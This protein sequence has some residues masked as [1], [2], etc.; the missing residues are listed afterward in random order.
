MDTNCGCKGGR[1]FCKHAAPI[2]IF[3]NKENTQSKTDSPMIWNRPPEVQLER[4][5]KGCTIEEMLIQKKS[6]NIFTATIPKQIFTFKD[7]RNID[8]IKF[9]NCALSRSLNAEIECV[10]S[11]LQNEALR[12]VE[13]RELQD[14]R[15]KMYQLQMNNTCSQYHAY[16]SSLNENGNLKLSR[17][18][19][20]MDYNLFYR[21]RVVVNKEKWERIFSNSIKQSETAI[22]F[23]ERYLR[24]TAS[25][26]AH[27]IKTRQTNFESLALQFKNQRYK[28]GLTDAMRYGLA[29]ESQAKLALSEQIGLKIYDS[30]LV[31]CIKQPFL[32]CSP[33]GIILNN[34][35]CELIEIKCPFSCQNSA[36]FDC[37]EGKSF[38]PYLIVNENN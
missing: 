23:T 29:M 28:G 37:I 2:C 8:N 27:R 30:G 6:N 19:C 33:D 5:R 10:N 3:V 1:G 22:W 11:R 9:E 20:P 13:A 14:L 25:Q 35:N 32:A 36:I 34:G 38:V 18:N 24:V 31:V 15:T 16:R 7:V 12:F 4:Y 17:M 21:S 26:K